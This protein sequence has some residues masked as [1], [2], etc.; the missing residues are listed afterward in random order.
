MTVIFGVASSTCPPNPVKCWQWSFSANTS[1]NKHSSSEL[2]FEFFGKGREAAHPSG[3]WHYSKWERSRGPVSYLHVLNLCAAFLA[4][5]ISPIR[6]ITGGCS[7]DQSVTVTV[8]CPFWMWVAS[9]CVFSDQHRESWVY[10]PCVCFVQ[11]NFTFQMDLY[12]ITKKPGNVCYIVCVMVHLDHGDI[13]RASSLDNSSSFVF[14]AS[15]A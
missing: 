14:T 13:Y 7:G 9:P 12:G 3:K 4:W 5:S 15:R 2:R 10:K 6:R 11:S 1:C 8:F